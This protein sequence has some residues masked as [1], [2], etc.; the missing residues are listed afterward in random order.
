M[1]FLKDGAAVRGQVDMGDPV[2]YFVCVIP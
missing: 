1:S 2:K